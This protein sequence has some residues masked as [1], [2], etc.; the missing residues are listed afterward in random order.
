MA[1]TALSDT[2]IRSL[3]SGTVISTPI[4]L[5]KELLENAIDAKATFIEV[6]VSANTVDKVEVRDNGTG[7]H[8]GDFDLLGRHGCTSK[9]K[10]F[11]DLVQ[12][13]GTSLG[14][15]GEALASA[16]TF[17]AVS[18]TTRSVEL[19]VATM[20]RLKGQG[21]GVK[22]MRQVCAPVGTTVEVTNIFSNLPVRKRIAIRDCSKTITKIKE[23]LYSYTLANPAVKL[24]FKV[25]GNNKISWSYA[26]GRDAGLQDAEAQILGVVTKNQLQ[27]TTSS[28]RERVPESHRMKSSK[29]ASGSVAFQALMPKVS[30]DVLT[31]GKGAFVSVDTRPISPATGT[32]KKLYQIFKKKIRCV[33]THPGV[34]TCREPLLILNIQCSPGTYDVN[35][36]PAKSDVLFADEDA[37]LGPFQDL[38]DEV[39]GKIRPVESVAVAEAL[40][41]FPNEIDST[42][43]GGGIASGDPDDAAQMALGSLPDDLPAGGRELGREMS[44]EASGDYDH[45][46]TRFEVVSEKQNEQLLASVP[47]PQVTT[48]HPQTKLVIDIFSSSKGKDIHVSSR[49]APGQQLHAAASQHDIEGSEHQPTTFQRPPE[50]ESC[51]ELVKTWINSNGDDYFDAAESTGSL[52]P[53]TI[54]KMKAPQTGEFRECDLV[55]TPPEPNPRSS[56][57]ASTEGSDTLSGLLRRVPNPSDGLTSSHQGTGAEDAGNGRYQTFDNPG[58]QRRGNRRSGFDR[59]AHNNHMPSAGRGS[60]TRPAFNGLQSPPPSSPIRSEA[61]GSMSWKLRPAADSHKFRQAT[62]FCGAGQASVLPPSTSE[63]TAVP[64]TSATKE[65]LTRL[66]EDSRFSPDITGTARSTSGARSLKRLKSDQLPLERTPPGQHTRHLCCNVFLDLSQLK[67]STTAFGACDQYILKGHNGWGM[68]TSLRKAIAQLKD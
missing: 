39:Y 47:A 18:V 59:S 46:K 26:P 65:L 21:Q 5:V 48:E 36:D 3:G 19:P 13:G 8:P 20:I 16:A 9:L 24:S 6:L 42:D 15:R 7:I 4:S 22:E 66:H 12:V 51:S 34:E 30:A 17:G 28:V 60:R 11:D 1:I 58:P 62:L 45:C 61:R 41:R 54:A 64:R 31:L 25:L 43:A 52:N 56:V 49:E 14:F 53:W 35:I 37:L 10:S 40:D 2:T 50:R 55:F 67:L 32:A 68:D 57:D 44:S 33:S 63:E 29:D 27:L 23:L 38:C